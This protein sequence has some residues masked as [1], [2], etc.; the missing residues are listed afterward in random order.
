MAP[1]QRVAR[2]A[3]EDRVAPRVGERRHLDRRAP[4]PAPQGG[5]KP[6]ILVPLMVAVVLVAIASVLAFLAGAGS[7]GGASGR[8]LVLVAGMLVTVASLGVL[9]TTHRTRMPKPLLEI[10][11][12]RAPDPNLDRLTGLPNRRGFVASATRLMGV[13]TAI[14]RVDL[15]GFDAVNAAFGSS[16]GDALAVQR[17][18]GP[19]RRRRNARRRPHG[20]CRR[21]PSRG[22]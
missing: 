13:P 5:V 14:V 7:G 12:D 11:G 16:V 1:S 3:V 8:S 10:A 6:A 17:R 20:R 22:R 21:G 2:G 15:D 4:E 19:H 9:W 18:R